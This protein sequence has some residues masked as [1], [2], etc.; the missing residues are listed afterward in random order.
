LSSQ[1]KESSLVGIVT[2]VS[3]MVSKKFLVVWNTLAV[4]GLIFLAFLVE[5]IPALL[6]SSLVIV[7]PALAALTPPG[8][9]WVGTFV[10]LG[11]FL[12]AAQCSFMLAIR[13]TQQ[14][15]R[16]SVSLTEWT[17]SGAFSVNLVVL[18][19]ALLS[20][21]W[22]VS[23]HQ[24]KAM[25]NW[26]ALFDLGAAV[27]TYVFLAVLVLDFAVC[28]GIDL[29]ERS[30]YRPS[31]AVTELTDHP[32]VTVVSEGET[33]VPDLLGGI[34]AVLEGLEFHDLQTALSVVKRIPSQCPFERTITFK[35]RTILKIPPLCKLNPLFGELQSLRF[36]A[37][38]Y[39]A[40]NG[41]DVSEFLG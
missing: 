13:F 20:R 29:T 32:G 39:L 14:V 24:H 25:L 41:M 35:G 15:L 27:H 4:R 40:D 6:L 28:V 37:L 33:P 9:A 19:G 23:L 12:V 34:R 3:A 38:T 7:Y 10:L 31:Y 30:V 26:G 16:D 18:V 2:L 5:G 8:D 21:D 1:E 22:C 17:L 36:R 11:L